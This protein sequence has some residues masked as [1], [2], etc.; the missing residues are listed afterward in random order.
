MS[1]ASGTFTANGSSS[2]I[3][4]SD[5]VTIEVP[6]TA[7]FS[8]TLVLETQWPDGTWSAF[9]GAAWTSAP[10]AQVLELVPNV[11]VPVRLTLSGSS[12]PSI[13]YL[14]RGGVPSI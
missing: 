4:A 6:S 11:L 2:A 1:Q 8:G 13:P 14:L 9:P 10:I 12:S 7:T 3:A 5:A